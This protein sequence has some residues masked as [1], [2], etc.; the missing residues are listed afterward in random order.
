M[1]YP[2]PGD[3]TG[4]GDNGIDQFRKCLEQLDALHKNSGPVDNSRSSNRS[5]QVLF[6]GAVRFTKGFWAERQSQDHHV[7]LKH[8]Y[9]MLNKAGNLH[10]L[11]M[12][13]GWESGSYRGMNFADENV[14]KWL[15]A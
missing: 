13:A 2:V 1:A 10:N 9:V 6:N 5:Y 8:G 4:L 14:Y 11:K 12:A 3:H 7:S 15:E